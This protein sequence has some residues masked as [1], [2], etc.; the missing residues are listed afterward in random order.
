MYNISLPQYL[1][2]RKLLNFDINLS[3]SHFYLS[4]SFSSFVRKSKQ[5]QLSFINSNNATGEIESN[6]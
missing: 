4:L 2:W 6:W 5:T 1:E 3:Y